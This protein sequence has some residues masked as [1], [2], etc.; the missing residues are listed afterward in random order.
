[1]RRAGCTLIYYGIESGSPAV[2][3]R[4]HQPIGLD[5]CTNIVNLTTKAGIR[6]GCYF[7]LGFPDETVGEMNETINYAYSLPYSSVS[8]IICLPLPGSSSY[9]A[10]LEQQGIDR[11][12]WSKYDFAK[13]DPLPCKP[14]PI[15]VRR[16]LFEANMLKRSKLAQRVYRFIH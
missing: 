12:D 9:K 4:L 15:Q 6:P 14:S 11:I 2:R 10:V 1:M 13:P 7:M 3:K 16:K 5:E 8:F